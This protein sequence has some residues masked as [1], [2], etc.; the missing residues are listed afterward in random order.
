M[1]AENTSQIRAT[2]RI[3][4]LV[5][6]VGA[7]QLEDLLRALPAIQQVKAEWQRHRIVIR[8]DPTRTAYEAIIQTLQNTQFAPS[9]TAWSR[10]K[11]KWFRFI[12]SNARDNAH[13]PPPACCNK[14]PK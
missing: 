13:A 12:D 6:S 5:D 11:L 9:D 10:L 1:K 8:Y 2:V 3:P 14:P 7:I 4:S